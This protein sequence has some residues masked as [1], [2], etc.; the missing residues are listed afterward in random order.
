MATSSLAMLPSATSPVSISSYNISHSSP[1]SWCPHW[2]LPSIY[3]TPCNLLSPVV[4]P[5]V[6]TPHNI[7]CCPFPFNVTHS[8][9]P[10]HRPPQHLTSL[11]P[12]VSPGDVYPSVISICHFAYYNVSLC[13]LHLQSCPHDV[14]HISLSLWLPVPV[15]YCNLPFQ[16]HL[17]LQSFPPY[18]MPLSPSC[19]FLLPSPM[20]SLVALSPAPISKVVELEKFI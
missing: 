2:S 6:I 11:Y 4:S 8:S 10:L 14:F 9:S 19:H 12:P 5:S 3:H 18:L 17:L 13:L 16:Y 20:S 1:L 7:S 15:L